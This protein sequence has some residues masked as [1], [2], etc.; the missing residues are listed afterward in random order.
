MDKRV[1]HDVAADNSNTAV[2]ERLEHAT[3]GVHSLENYEP[4]I[5]TQAVQRILTKADALKSSRIAHISS[6]FYG[7]GVAEILTPLTLLMNAT[8]IETVWHLVQGTPAFF[9]CTKML[10]NALQGDSIGLTAEEKAIYQEVL[11]ENSMRLHIED[12]DAVIVHDPQ[13]LPL[14]TQF[15]GRSAPWIWQCHVDLS[16]PDRSTWNY[17]RSFVERYDL[18]V[19]S[20]PEYRQQL[21]IPQRFIRPA[22]DPFSAKNCELPHEDA[23]GILQR[24]DIPTDRPIVAQVSRFDR[25]KDPAGVI[26]AFR[27]ARRQ[28]DCTLVLLGNPAIDDPEAGLVL[29]SI[30]SSLDERVLIITVDDPL[31]VNALQRE[32]AV[33]LQK[34]LREGFGMTVTEAMW[35]G[36][37]VIGG[38]VGGIR[39]QIVDGENGFLVDSVDEAAERIV[40]LLK[41]EP[42]RKRLGERARESVR[43]QYLLSHL[44]EEWIDTIVDVTRS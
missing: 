21:D 9:G 29:E 37:A 38:N 22:I 11:S 39:K 43:A 24:H 4:L 14:I 26:E 25:W 34:S 28:V 2:S 18:A 30:Q 36:A 23:I 32:A 1:S 42:L 20:L 19:F 31:L 12:C 8:G 10:H 5:G 41:D 7:G 35:K 27:K 15:E 44:L 33:V 3:L 17:L 16:A 13:P 6:T 40:R